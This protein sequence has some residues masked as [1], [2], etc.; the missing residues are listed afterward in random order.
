MNVALD[1][2][3]LIYAEDMHDAARRMTALRFMEALVGHRRYVPVQVLGEFH[4]V[5][6]RKLRMDQVEIAGLV[7]RWTRHVE[8]IPT[9]E[10]VFADACT[11]AANHQFDIWD[12]IILAAAAEAKCDLLLSEDGHSGFHWRGVTVVDPFAGELHPLAVH[13]LKGK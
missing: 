6:R 13:L 1:T 7:T 11:L 9:T 2:N 10:T 8:L 4:R 12:A 5:L 3:F